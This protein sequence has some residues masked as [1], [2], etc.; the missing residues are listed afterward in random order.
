MWIFAK[1]KRNETRMLSNAKYLKSS[2]ECKW[3]Q[4][5]TNLKSG[6][7]NNEH[8]GKLKGVLMLKY[9]MFVNDVLIEW[10]SMCNCTC[11]CYT[12]GWH[13]STSN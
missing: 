5:N 6:I 8:V 13:E 4:R 1:S 3:E 11:I 10:K 12:C 7:W 9:E 2:L